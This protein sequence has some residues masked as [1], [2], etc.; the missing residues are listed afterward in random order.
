MAFIDNT[1]SSILPYNDDEMKYDLHRRMYVITD[2]GVNRL[3]GIDLVS[4]A[5][6]QTEAD[7]IK[8]EVSQDIYNIISMYSMIGSYLYKVFQIAKDEDLREK[9]K[10]ILADQIRYYVR[11]GAG[12]LKD[13]HGVHIEKGKAIDISS[14]RGRVLISQSAEA[15]LLQAG[16]LY[17]GKLYYP[18]YD[19]D[20]TW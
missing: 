2:V 15:L 4:I 9:F 10:R 8:Y 14:I 3:T 17:T 16:L 7:L 1:D 19:D 6:S 5:G 12:V 20:G 18:D 13:Q 11:S